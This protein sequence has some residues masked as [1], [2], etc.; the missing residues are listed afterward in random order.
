M[1]KI[2]IIF[3]LLFNIHNVNAEEIYKFDEQSCKEIYYGVISFLE[4]T[5][6]AF[7]EASK[8]IINKEETIAKEK[9]EEAFGLTQ[10][11]ANYT[12]VFDVFC[13]KRN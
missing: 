8:A 6:K 4:N 3:I 9:Y 5:D 11:A 1:K 12:Q 10:L 2:T 13:T 7:K